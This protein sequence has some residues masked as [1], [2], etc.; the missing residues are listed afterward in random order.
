MKEIAL[1]SSVRV[2]G[3]C[4]LENSDFWLGEIPYTLLMRSPDDMTV[5]S[6]PSMLNIRNLILAVLL[7]LAAVAALG[8]WGWTQERKSRQKTLALTARIEAEAEH[9]RHSVQLEQKRSRILEDINGDR[10]LAEILEGIAEMIS[11]ALKGFPC[12]C[13]LN[14]GAT[15]GVSPPERSEVRVIQI[16]I[17]GRSGA[18][19]GTIF[20]GFDPRF[21]PLPGQLE[22]LSAGARLAALAIETRR[23]YS[24]LR[25][26]SEFDLLTHIHNRFSMERELDARILDAQK[27]NGVFGLIYIDLDGFK[28]INDTRGHRVGD[29]YLQAAADRMNHQLRP[30]DLLAR[31]GGDEFAALV[32]DV[33]CRTDVQEI[34]L[35]LERCFDDPFVVEGALL[36]GGASFGIAFYPDDGATEDSLLNAADAAMYAV[37]NAKRAREKRTA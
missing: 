9:E 16:S 25:H 13:E 2:T 1:G 22:A 32:S 20:S 36:R 24:D 21:A 27:T 15:I 12:W 17:V 11:F 10:S 8:A 3:I 23:L 31:L 26:R 7:L 6:G 28:Q 34:A 37:K 5:I 29:L 18:V 14:D 33:R 30:H 35:R 4:V 19:L